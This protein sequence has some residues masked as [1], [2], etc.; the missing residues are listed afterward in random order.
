MSKLNEGQ[1]QEDLKILRKFINSSGDFV[2]EEYGD[3]E[4]L[5][6]LKNLFSDPGLNPMSIPFNLLINKKF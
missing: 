6:N 4:V 5:E 2:D 3:N 1:F